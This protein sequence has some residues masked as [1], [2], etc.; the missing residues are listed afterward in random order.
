[1]LVTNPSNKYFKYHEI[2]HQLELKNEDRST[3]FIAINNLGYWNI[4]RK[5]RILLYK[6]YEEKI[7]T[8]SP[9]ID[10]VKKDKI[11]SKLFSSSSIQGNINEY[12]K[13]LYPKNHFHL[14]DDKFLEYLKY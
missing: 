9:A 8:I 5:R 11:Y 6:T 3:P 12:I 14:D 10:L 13:S 7:E 2:I 4:R 1:M